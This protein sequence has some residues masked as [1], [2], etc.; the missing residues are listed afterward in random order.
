MADACEDCLRTQLGW[1]EEGEYPLD[2]DREDP[3][4][5]YCVGGVPVITPHKGMIG[6]LVSTFNVTPPTLGASGSLEGTTFSIDYVNTT[7]REVN[8]GLFVSGNIFFSGADTITWTFTY[9]VNIS[10]STGDLSLVN[11]SAIAVTDYAGIETIPLG[12]VTG[13]G[14]ISVGGTLHVDCFI[15]YTSSGGGPS[16]AALHAA[17]LTALV[18]GGA[19]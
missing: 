13:P 17:N 15:N 7:P 18:I 1:G 16:V 2:P 9:G 12:F 8:F 3:E 4:R 19:P 14:I 10:V 11:T 6:P 5:I